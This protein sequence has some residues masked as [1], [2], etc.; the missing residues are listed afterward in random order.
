MKN[1]TAYFCI[2]FVFCWRDYEVACPWN[3]AEKFCYFSKKGLDKTVLFYY[4]YIY[5]SSISTDIA[6]VLSWIY[7]CVCVNNIRWIPWWRPFWSKQKKPTNEKKAYW[8]IRPVSEQPKSVQSRSQI[9]YI[10]IVAVIL[11][12]NVGLYFA[13]TTTFWFSEIDATCTC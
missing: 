13:Q 2:F 8:K 3:V 12:L 6:P 7:F 1:I 11:L 4:S 5:T 9:L 10:G